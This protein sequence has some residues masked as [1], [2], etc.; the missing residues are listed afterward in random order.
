MKTVY[1]DVVGVRSTLSVKERP[2]KFFIKD[3]LDGRWVPITEYAPE[4]ERFGKFCD[5]IKK[6]LQDVVDCVAVPIS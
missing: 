5:E 3:F 2:K 6:E 4:E 1:Q